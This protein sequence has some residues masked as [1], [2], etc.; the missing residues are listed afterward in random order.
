LCYEPPSPNSDKKKSMG[1]AE[2]ISI[3]KS[4]REKKYIK[5]KDAKPKKHE[6]KN[7]DE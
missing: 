5:R 6:L 1:Y 4:M 7:D 3:P 2:N